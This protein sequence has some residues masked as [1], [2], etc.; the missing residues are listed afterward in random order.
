MQTMSLGVAYTTPAS[1]VAARRRDPRRAARPAA[2]GKMRKN[3]AVFLNST[4]SR[5]AAGSVAIA[6][7]A[8]ACECALAGP[9]SPRPTRYASPA[10]RS[11]ASRVRTRPLCLRA[12]RILT[13]AP[14]V[15]A[16]ES[17]TGPVLKV[18]VAW[19]TLIVD[20]HLR[21]GGL[22]HEEGREATELEDTLVRPPQGLPHLRE[23]G[24][25]TSRCSAY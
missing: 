9:A 2:P 8:P 11:S 10:P 19:G 16:A 24:R 3:S 14:Q 1:S 13:W 5:S 18:R 4:A 20:S 21:A 7:G 12:L 6:C 22:A 23:E 17:P 15:N 25:R